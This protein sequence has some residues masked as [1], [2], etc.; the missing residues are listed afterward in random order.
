M[1]SKNQIELTD[2]EIRIINGALSLARW[3]RKDII[4]VLEKGERIVADYDELKQE[5]RDIE[6]LEDRFDEICKDWIF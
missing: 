4:D 1:N 3:R 2:D 6:A 5:V